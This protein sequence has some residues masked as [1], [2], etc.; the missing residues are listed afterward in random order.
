ME[1]IQVFLERFRVSFAVREV[2]LIQLL[3]HR[4]SNALLGTIS[5]YQDKEIVQPVMQELIQVLPERL[6]VSFAIPEVSLIQLLKHHANNALLD[7]ISRYQVKVSA[8]L[9]V[10]ALIL[11]SGQCSVLRVPQDITVQMAC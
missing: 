8:R 1:L 4:V 9:V 6:L 7:I 10:L 5:R 2:S 11:C 3:K